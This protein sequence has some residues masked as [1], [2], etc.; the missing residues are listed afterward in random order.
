MADREVVVFLDVDGVLNKNWHGAEHAGVEGA[1]IEAEMVQQLNQLLI[2]LEATGDAGDSRPWL[3]LSST[4]R[5]DKGQ[6]AALITHL[7]AGGI[8]PY[9]HPT[10]PSTPD[11]DGG[12]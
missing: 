7:E 1:D 2:G 9:F 11:I 12:G 10:N 4:W 5:R 3:V 8:T 6:H